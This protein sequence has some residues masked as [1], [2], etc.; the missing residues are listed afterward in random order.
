MKCY[1]NREAPKISALSL[2]KTDKNEYLT[3]EEIIT[4]NHTRIIQKARFTYS[5]L[6]KELEKNLETIKIKGKTKK[7]D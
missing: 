2:G 4:L 6:G 3:D 1:I 7:S 5:P